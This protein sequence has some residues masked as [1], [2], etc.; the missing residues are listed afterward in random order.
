[1]PVSAEKILGHTGVKMTDHLE[2]STSEETEASN[3]GA[4]VARVVED[5]FG[6][7]RQ[8]GL[9]SR[10][11]DKRP[12]EDLFGCGDLRSLAVPTP[13]CL[14]GH[15]GDRDHELRERSND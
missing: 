4:S 8:E 13:A 15:P 7:Q 3:A 14:M 6:K 1:M 12:T 9:L 10:E 11:A 2:Y 5:Q